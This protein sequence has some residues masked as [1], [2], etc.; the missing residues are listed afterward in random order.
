M[1]IVIIG[2]GIG[3]MT[4]AI[5]LK[6]AG[7][8]VIICEKE[9]GIPARGNAFLMHAEGL[10]IIESL[11]PSPNKLLL[12]GKMIDSFMLKRP[13][14]TTVKYQKLNPWQCIKRSD[15]IAFLYSLMPK[16]NILSNRAFSHFQYDSNNIEV[17]AVFENGEIEYGDVFIG[18]DG[19]YSAVRNHLFGTTTF[20]P[21]EVKE[22]VGVATCPELVQQHPNLF[23]KFLSK[24]KGLSFG[25]IPTSDTELVWFMQFDVSLVQHKENTECMKEI[26]N[27]L[28]KD[29]PAD[30]Q[31]I[32]QQNDFNTT[33]TWNTRDFDLLPSFHKN[34]VVLIG[35]AAH[36][37][38]PFT[39][40]GTTNALKDALAIT[41]LL[42]TKETPEK[43]FEAF[44]AERAPEVKEHTLLGRDLKY[45]FLHPEVDNDDD[46]KIPLIEKQLPI[47]KT[48][49]VYK[50][51]HVLYFTDP[52]CS[53]CWLI[54]P[55]LRRLK[56]EYGD[57]L[58]IEYCMGGLLPSWE[59]FNRGGISNPA[60]A[61][62]NWRQAA[63]QNEM[64]IN[65]D[66][67]LYNPLPSSYPPSIAFKAAQMQDTDKSII[68][69]RRINEMLFL[70]SKNIIE[71]VLLHNA[72]YDA[73][74]DA[75]RLMR[76]LEGK[77]QQLFEADLELARELQISILP[78]F[79]FTDKFNNSTVLK[80]FQQYDAFENTLISFIP[81]AKK[82]TIKRD[83]EA[84]FKVFPTLTTKEF[85][86]LADVDIV[87]A[88]ELLTS[89][90]KDGTI[91]QQ[92][93][94]RSGIIWKLN[95]NW[96]Q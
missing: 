40:A 59:N 30:V 48:R 16:E 56:L 31:S 14:D 9:T 51:V 76:D 21:V 49:P 37:A 71:N 45:K 75:A 29:F 43:A 44:Y 5:L 83:M 27:L 50:K 95:P 69:L 42:A 96:F 35:D 89:L 41:R 13:D 66:I 70:E 46:I 55:Q 79:I 72:A 11:N 80:G 85:S 19:A 34:N 2:G 57:Y 67:W 86:F 54:Q 22:F 6:N 58:E 81:F 7:F 52:V 88:E 73:G 68:F 10:D 33:Y 91:L 61:A 53:T 93:N 1:K 18:S 25:Y 39:S 74:L 65:P 64:P 63:L 62:E 8:K 36:L 94:N 24:E 12:P 38:L 84:L 23:K 60:E 4:T 82:K 20:T 28:L 78:T 3:G 47:E 90:F 17:A 87:T 92:V 15:L 32:L 77:A 26:S